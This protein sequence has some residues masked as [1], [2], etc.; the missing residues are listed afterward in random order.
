[1]KLTNKIEAKLTKKLRDDIADL[2][3]NAGLDERTVMSIIRPEIASFDDEMTDVTYNYVKYLLYLRSKGQSEAGA[4][5][6]FIAKLEKTKPTKSRRQTNDQVYS[7]ETLNQRNREREK[8]AEIYDALHAEDALGYED[9]YGSVVNDPKVKEPQVEEQGAEIRDVE[10]LE[11]RAAEASDQDVMAHDVN[12]AEELQD[13]TLINQ[14][15]VEDL[16]TELELEDSF[17]DYMETQTINVA[18]DQNPE[19]TVPSEADDDNN[20]AVI[21]EVELAEME[22]MAD[23]DLVA[24]DGQEMID[25]DDDNQ[26][27]DLAQTVRNLEQTVAALADQIMYLETALSD[28]EIAFNAHVEGDGIEVSEANVTL[29]TLIA[30]EAA[31]DEDITSDNVDLPQSEAEAQAAFDQANDEFVEA[32]DDNADNSSN[33]STRNALAD[34]EQ[35]PEAYQTTDQTIPSTLADDL[36]V[37]LVDTPDSVDEITGLKTETFSTDQDSA[38]AP[39]EEAVDFDSIGVAV[40]IPDSDLLDAVNNTL[41]HEDDEAGFSDD[42]TTSKTPNQ[43]DENLAAYDEAMLAG[44][45]GNDSTNVTTDQTSDEA[46]TNDEQVKEAEAFGE[47]QANDDADLNDHDHSEPSLADKDLDDDSTSENNEMFSEDQSN[48]SAVLEADDH[49]DEAIATNP[50]ED[51]TTNSVS[52]DYES[53]WDQ[54]LDAEIAANPDENTQDALDTG[55]GTNEF[56][57][58]HEFDE[59]SKTSS[60]DQILSAMPNDTD[61]APTMGEELTDMTT[62]DLA[63]GVDD[64]PIEA[65]DHSLDP[66][67]EADLKDSADSTDDQTSLEAEMNDPENSDD[68]VEAAHNEAKPTEATNLDEPFQESEVVEHS[69]DVIGQE[70]VGEN[71]EDDFI[72]DEVNNSTNQPAEGP[73]ALEADDETDQEET[74]IEQDSIADNGQESNLDEPFQEDEVVEHSEDVIGQEEIGENDEDDFISDEVNNSDFD[75]AEGAPLDNQSTLDVTEAAVPETAPIDEKAAPSAIEANDAKTATDNDQT[76]STDQNDVET[77]L[78]EPF[79]ESEVVK[80]A[81]DVTSQEEIG[82]NDEDDFISD[83][84]DNSTNQPAEGPTASEADAEADQEETTIEQDS[85]ADNDQESNLDEPFQEDEVVEHSQ[86]S[87]PQE[88]IGENDEDDQIS[89]EVNNSSFAPAEGPV[90]ETSDLSNAM[91]NVDATGPIVDSETEASEKNLNS[92]DYN[93]QDK[94][95]EQPVAEAKA[96]NAET[97]TTQ[98]EENIDPEAEDALTDAFVRA[99]LGPDVQLDDADKATEKGDH[100]SFD[101]QS[102]EI[103]LTLNTN[104]DETATNAEAKLDTTNAEDQQVHQI[105]DQELDDIVDAITIKITEEIT[106]SSG[107]NEDGEPDVTKYVTMNV[108][109]VE[110]GEEVLYNDDIYFIIGAESTDDGIV[111]KLEP[112]DHDD[113]QVIEVP[114]NKVREIK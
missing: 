25:L 77:N 101:G 44:Q 105:S 114:A 33:N 57:T 103:D 113:D 40:Q 55:G 69:E 60:T 28:L 64:N 78:D 92:Q 86:E 17:Q 99:A 42:G 15:Q 71:D 87:T 81:Q 37:A 9:F 19:V 5:E 104:A 7:K 11:T 73:T 13:E 35:N 14:M 94:L 98:A 41:A 108:E 31:I 48:N 4:Y 52:G 80:H 76:S 50:S 56:V 36:D 95:I 111:L 79:Q 27:E 22:P 45:T 29:N 46:H 20:A 96:G 6:K 30:D 12:Q 62:V 24:D 32:H 54:D 23:V 8:I 65:A 61:S 1:M 26:T 110:L 70:E 59:T 63:S 75:P 88:E 107:T 109:D 83:E 84:V 102:T 106:I 112:K 18:A 3:F 10:V 93:Q 16:H 97:L 51:T 21:A 39:S 53:K 82:E 100:E 49:Q 89:D 90:D 43:M 47:V 67:N 2:V 91:N 66:F 58:T 34:A 72:S 85:I 38:I 74:T 68:H